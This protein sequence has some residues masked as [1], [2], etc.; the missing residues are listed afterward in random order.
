MQFS[1]RC[2]ATDL[3]R[4]SKEI[5][6][7]DA[8]RALRFLISNYVRECDMSHLIANEVKIQRDATRF[9]AFSIKHIDDKAALFIQTRDLHI[10]PAIIFSSPR[11]NAVKIWYFDLFSLYVCMP[12]LFAYSTA[13]QHHFIFPILGLSDNADLYPPPISHSSLSEHL[14]VFNRLKSRNSREYAS[15]LNIFVEMS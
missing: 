14:R 1:V 15:T 13:T 4:C 3:S 10:T 5:F 8:L 12:R 2:E 11:C 7:S 6:T 9:S